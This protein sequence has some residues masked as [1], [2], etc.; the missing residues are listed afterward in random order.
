M[1]HSNKKNQ[2]ENKDENLTE[3]YDNYL[4]LKYLNISLKEIKELDPFERK[5]YVD[6]L[7]KD[8]EKKEIL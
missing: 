7:K 8:L 1:V 2:M 6:F 4:L 5:S 3:Y